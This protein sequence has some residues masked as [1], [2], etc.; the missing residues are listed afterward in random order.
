MHKFT[1]RNNQTLF[2]YTRELYETFVS[3]VISNSF[4]LV[5]GYHREKQLYTTLGITAGLTHV[6]TMGHSIYSN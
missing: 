1:I 2:Q 4:K 5:M 3:Y 6:L